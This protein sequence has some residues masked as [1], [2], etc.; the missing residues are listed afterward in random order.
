MTIYKYLIECLDEKIVK[1]Y[2]FEAEN[3]IVLRLHGGE[4]Y[5]LNGT[6]AE[7]YWRQWE[8]ET[9]HTSED[10]TDIC[11]IWREGFNVEKFFIAGK[12]ANVQTVSPTTWT[13]ED[14]EKF[15]SF[16]ERRLQSKLKLPLNR[17][18]IRVETEGGQR[19][20]IGTLDKPY[21]STDKQKIPP[22]NYNS[23]TKPPKT[24]KSASSPTRKKNS[25]TAVDIF[26]AW[27]ELSQKHNTN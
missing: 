15:F 24:E 18:I 10:S 25:A 19:F 21:P 8:Q 5:T 17:T 20:L 4:T 6:N 3:F 1:T 22:T 26:E 11:V 2:S 9:G 14:I 7:N 23:N 16:T 13:N 12:D 27:R